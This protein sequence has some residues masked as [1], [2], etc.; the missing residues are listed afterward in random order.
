M[1]VDRA[2]MQKVLQQAYKYPDTPIQT[3]VSMN[4]MQLPVTE[5]T[6]AGFEQYQTNQHAMMQALSGMTE[7]LTAYM[8]EPDSMREMLQVLSDA[9]DLPVLD[10]DAM[11]QELEQT[12]CDVMFAQ[13][14]VS[15]GD[16]LQATD[17]TGNPPV[18]SA[19]Q[20]TTY[21]EKFGMT[22]E[23]LTGLTKQ[24]QDMHFDAQTIQTVLAKSDTTMQLA[25]HLQ[26]LVA[27]AADKSMINAETMKEFFTSD[28]MK[29]LLAAAVKE[30]FTLNPEKMQNPQEVRSE[31]HTSELQSR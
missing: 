28:G 2:S 11:L 21:A 17:M 1:P 20:L 15:A 7:E 25:N 12:T 26:A 27:G 13:G 29:E 4:K 14:A 8:S 9:Q 16:Q 6:I 19:E 10:A 23:Q 22:E 3:L 5:Q 18:L 31:E 24:L 30:K